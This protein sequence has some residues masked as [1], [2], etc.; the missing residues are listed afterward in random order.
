MFIK[1]L[2]LIECGLLKE[3][4][5]S[6]KIRAAWH[7][8]EDGVRSLDF[9]YNDISGYGDRLDK[10]IGLLKE[11]I[12]QNGVVFGA[13]D[14]TR[15]VGIASVIPNPVSLD[16][17]A[18][19]V[20][21]DVTKEKRCLGIG[22]LL[23]E[24]CV[25]EA[26]KQGCKALVAASN[27]HENTIKFCKSKG[28]LYL[29]DNEIES[30]KILHFPI[31][32]FPEPFGEGVERIVY[33]VLPIHEYK[34]RNYFTDKITLDALNTSNCYGAMKLA[35]KDEQSFTFGNNPIFTIAN[36][37]FEK[38]KHYKMLVAH[39]DDFPVGFMGY[40]VSADQTS[41]YI[42][43]IMVDF[44][45]QHKGIA[46][47][48]IELFCDKL[49]N[50]STCKL[51]KLG[52]RTDNIAAAKTYENAGFKLIKVDGLSSYREKEI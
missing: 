45:F 51:I 33:L 38:D 27:P 36:S 13:F 14:E 46:L 50:E 2:T 25:N 11:V 39:F 48:M 34:N 24:A 10:C 37:I 6:E 3:I 19:L 30:S 21:L 32:D 20:S 17:Y 47:T 40:S 15:I 1:E 4:D 12:K 9:I 41:A 52:N 29:K 18:L 26:K 31:F 8:N 7:K 23:L 16:G 49:R 43:P 28:F 42:E 5:R 35:V 22:S 44:M